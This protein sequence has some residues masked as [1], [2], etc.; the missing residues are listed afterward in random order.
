MGER[1]RTPG[2][3]GNFEPMKEPRLSGGQTGAFVQCSAPRISPHIWAQL[4]G[5]MMEG[6][7]LRSLAPRISRIP[8]PSRRRAEHMMTRVPVFQGPPAGSARR[9]R[10]VPSKCVRSSGLGRGAAGGRLP[11]A[12]SSS[13]RPSALLPM[14][15]EIRTGGGAAAEGCCGSDCGRT[16]GRRAGRRERAVSPRS[17]VMSSPRR[18]GVESISSAG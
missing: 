15:A 5:G 1:G 3:A 11:P 4:G 13:R 6:E 17:G 7:A 18:N 14:W 12:G 16:R 10:K 2:S 8:C 9:G